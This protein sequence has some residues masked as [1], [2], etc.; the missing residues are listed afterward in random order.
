MCGRCLYKKP[1]KEISDPDVTHSLRLGSVTLS[2]SPPTHPT[3][4]LTGI[5]IPS[6]KNLVAC[7]LVVVNFYFFK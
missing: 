1:I 5:N 3:A 2:R 4:P 6:P 7:F